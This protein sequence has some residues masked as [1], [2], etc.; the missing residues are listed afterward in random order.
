MI[1]I[2]IKIDN[3]NINDEVISKLGDLLKVSTVSK[4]TSRNVNVI[5]NGEVDPETVIKTVKNALSF[6]NEQE[7]KDDSPQNNTLEN[8]N[9]DTELKNLQVKA[10]SLFVNLVDANKEKA[11]EIITSFNAKSYEGIKKSLGED[12][13]KWKEFCEMLENI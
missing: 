13:N 9:N 5:T 12:V 11:R 8:N 10:K 7:E 4:E 3:E 1:S 2:E 6:E